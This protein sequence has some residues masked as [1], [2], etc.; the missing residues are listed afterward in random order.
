MTSPLS[1]HEYQL[2]RCFFLPNRQA[3]YL[4]LLADHKRRPDVLKELAHF[5]HLDL[6]WA[7]ALPPNCNR[8]IS[9]AKLLQ[10]KGAPAS[11][12]AISESEKLD[13]KELDLLEAL[14]EIVGCGM[15]T[16]LS[17]LPGQLAYFEDEENR[18]LLHRPD[19]APADH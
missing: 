1:Y 14:D 4:E 13:G 16:F 5:K 2:V 3:R 12:W 6:R 9:I 17:C 11:C 10:S 15:G 19:S 18:Y 8:P 7:Q